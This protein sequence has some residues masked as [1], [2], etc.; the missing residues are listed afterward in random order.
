MVSYTIIAVLLVLAVYWRVRYIKANKTNKELIAGLFR[1]Q[2]KVKE[3]MAVEY[4]EQENIQYMAA[5]MD[6]AEEE[7]KK[8]S[9]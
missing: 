5:F 1:V 6:R 4:E 8:A 2:A 7:L 3:M 9:D